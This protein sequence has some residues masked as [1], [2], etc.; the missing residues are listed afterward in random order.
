MTRVKELLFSLQTARMVAMGPVELIE[1]A[2]GQSL[3][4]SHKILAVCAVVRICCHFET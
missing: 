4:G 2:K 3:F 1:L